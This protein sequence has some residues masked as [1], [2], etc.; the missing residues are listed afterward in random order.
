M[1]IMYVGIIG[2]KFS[3]ADLRDLIVESDVLAIELVDKVL[4]GKMYN[5]AVRVHKLVYEGLYRFLLNM[6]EDKDVDSFKYPQKYP[7]CKRK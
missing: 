6:M 1:I 7:I 4:S 2:K 5:R 3:K